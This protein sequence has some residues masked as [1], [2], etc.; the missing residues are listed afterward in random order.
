MTGFT[1]SMNEMAATRHAPREVTRACHL[2][3]GSFV[4]GLI[5]LP[6]L[7]MSHPPDERSGFAIFMGVLIAA[8]GALTLWLV[9]KIKHRRNWA[10]WVML[11]LVVMGSASTLHSLAENWS[12]SAVTTL[13]DGIASG[14]DLGAIWLLFARRG[15][16]WFAEQLDVSSLVNAP[17]ERDPAESGISALGYAC[18]NC[19]LRIAFLSKVVQ[20]FGKA[21]TCPYCN[22]SIKRDIAYGKF[23]ALMFL[24]GLPIKLLGK[25]IP[26]VSFLEG[27]LT[28]ALVT[29]FLILLSL[30]FKPDPG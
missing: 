15:N 14:M 25:I 12:E 8:V 20:A 30:R 29:G 11:G 28:T 13:L 27:S 18:P 10:R 22:Q 1:S 9:S 6:F 4:L 7:V 3:I 5:P 23:I 2:L 16:D 19:H 21:Q 17:T 24:V 26:A